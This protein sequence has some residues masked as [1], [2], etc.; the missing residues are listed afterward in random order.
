MSKIKTLVENGSVIWLI[1][2]IVLLISLC[3][4]LVIEITKKSSNFSLIDT[5]IWNVITLT[6]IKLVFPIEKI[7][8]I[9]I[10]LLMIYLCVIRAKNFDK[11][12]EK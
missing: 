3:M 7:S 8:Y 11:K 2:G 6:V 9:I 5:L 12:L 4:L 10:V 1:R